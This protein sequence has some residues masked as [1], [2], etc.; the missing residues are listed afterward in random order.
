MIEVIPPRVDVVSP[1]GA[2]DAMAAAFTWAMERKND[3]RDALRWGV[4]AGSASTQLPGL[5]FA[6]FAQTEE[7]YKNV[8]IRKV[9]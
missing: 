3:F 5:Q 7:V 2:G 1:I 4:A 8:E 6:S 9:E